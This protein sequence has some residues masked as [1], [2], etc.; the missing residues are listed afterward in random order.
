MVLEEGMEQ[1]DLREGRLGI[2]YMGK[3]RLHGEAGQQQRPV[4][5]RGR[6]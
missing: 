1:P 6:F 4:M 5:T 3:I 2:K